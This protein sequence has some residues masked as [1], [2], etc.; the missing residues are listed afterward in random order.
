M[1]RD[2]Q[3]REGKTILR[4]QY[5]SSARIEEDILWAPCD[6]CITYL[7]WTCFWNPEMSDEYKPAYTQQTT[8]SLNWVCC[9]WTIWMLSRGRAEIEEK[10]Q[11][12]LQ[13]ELTWNLCSSIQ[14]T[15]Y[16][17]E[18]ILRARRSRYFLFW[19][20]KHWTLRT[21]SRENGRKVNIILYVKFGLR[22]HSLTI[23]L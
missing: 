13:L 11:L 7:R 16:L 8:T 14:K 23:D 9:I 10:C 6:F 15:L 12:I 17:N 2:T 19:S 1:K 4:H 5:C 22:L 20:Q 18:R 21:C 3:W